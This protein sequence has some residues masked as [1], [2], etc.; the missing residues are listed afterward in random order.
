MLRRGPGGKGQIPSSNQAA[1]RLGWTLTKFNRKLDNVCEKLARIG[2][3]GL[4]GASGQSA[5][6]R[7]VRLV[8]YAVATRLITDAD[9]VLL[10]DA[11][12]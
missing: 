5:S 9:L 6:S 2:V 11:V 4:V 12:R 7:R 1:E 3:S 8:E 10:D